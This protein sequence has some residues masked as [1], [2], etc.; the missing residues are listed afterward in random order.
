[1]RQPER[2][3]YVIET[4]GQRA[5]C[6]LDVQTEAGIANLMRRRK[7]QFVTG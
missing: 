5:C 6:P 7:W 3:K 2:T 4:P 1:M